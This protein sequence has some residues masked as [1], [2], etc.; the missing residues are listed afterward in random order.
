MSTTVSTTP[1]QPSARQLERERYRRNRTVRSALIALVSTAVV[2]AVVAL[3]VGSSSGWPR[4][5]DSFFDLGAGF[6]DLPA[7]LRALWVNVQIM[8]IAE[9]C[10]L[11]LGALL[12][13]V[14]TL[15]GPVFFPLRFLATAYVDVFRGLPLLIVLY[16]VGF[17]LPA[18]RIRQFPDSPFVLCIIALVLTYSAYVAEVF[19]AG[20]ES[21]HPSQR[22]AA[23]SLGLT[24]A[25][26]MRHVVFPQ[27][28][29]RVLPPLLNDFVS[30]QKDTSLVS[31]LAVSEMVLV[32]Q[33]QVSQDY[34][35]VHYLMA[36]LVFVL[37]A[38]PLTR[39]TDWIARRQGWVGSAATAIR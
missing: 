16:C 31:V 27:A 39:L 9:V 32:A 25:Q 12:A 18:L 3:A 11:V 5:R 37:L 29:R 1:W 4:M 34:K 35:F 38:V 23:R 26:T 36:G 21:V 30:L 10:V 20:I 7:L 17:G 24:T 8:V 28:V 2:L 6:G 15:Q 19:R 22:A 14:R 33:G 13:I